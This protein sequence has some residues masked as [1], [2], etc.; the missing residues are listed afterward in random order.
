MA[1]TEFENIIT[2][3]KNAQLPE[4][5]SF[6]EEMENLFS[7]MIRRVKEEHLQFKKW[8]M[9]HGFSQ[10]TMNFINLINDGNFNNISGRYSHQV[11]SALFMN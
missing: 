3:N 9:V 11:M 2:E 6:Q 1:W 5:Y 4:F 8:V 10:E 7:T